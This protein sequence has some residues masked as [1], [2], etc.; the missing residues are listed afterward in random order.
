MEREPLIVKIARIDENV[1]HL[2]E[3][4]IPIKKKVDRHDKEL[5]TI[6]ILFL[7]GLVVAAFKFPVLM[8]LVTG[9]LS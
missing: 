8:D 7:V 1:K 2:K 9:M 3:L 5:W 6:R 4:V